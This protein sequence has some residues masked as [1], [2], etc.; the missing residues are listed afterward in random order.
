LWD[1]GDG[2]S[3]NEFEPIYQYTEPG[4][5]D[6]TLVVYDTNGCFSSDSVTITV[7][8]GA[9]EGG[10]VQPSNPICPGDS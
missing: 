10:V 2:N 9:F 5:Y 8:I 4:I 1:F 7:I 3:S 6:V